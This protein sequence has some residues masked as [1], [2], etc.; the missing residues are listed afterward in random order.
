MSTTDPL[1]RRR[2]L[3]AILSRIIALTDGSMVGSALSGWCHREGVADVRPD[4]TKEQA[5]ERVLS[6]LLD[7]VTEATGSLNLPAERPASIEVTL[8][9]TAIWVE[10]D[11]LGCRHVMM[12]HE[13]LPAF[14]YASFNYDWRYTDNAGTLRAA[15]MVAQ[16]LGAPLPIE[17]RHRPFSLEA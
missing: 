15:E 3:T 7:E 8:L 2:T 6:A 9:P 1:F 14:T 13:G 12:Q 10:S 5:H 17:H 16:G 11:I 4:S